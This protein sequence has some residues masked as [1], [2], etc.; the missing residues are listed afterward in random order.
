MLQRWLAVGN[1]VFDLTGPRF[2]SQIS[3]SGDE[4]VTAQS[5]GRYFDNLSFPIF[6]F[7]ASLKRKKFFEFSTNHGNFDEIADILRDLGN[8]EK[9]QG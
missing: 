2:E 8:F 5:T 7:S 4:C 1:S 3:C 9:F 6:G